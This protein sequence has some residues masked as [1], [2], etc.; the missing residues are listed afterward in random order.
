MSNSSIRKAIWANGVSVC[1]LVASLFYSST[2]LAETLVFDGNNISILQLD[3]TGNGGTYKSLYSTDIYS[4]NVVTVDGGTGG[5][6]QAAWTTTGTINAPYIIYGGVDVQLNRAT[7]EGVTAA[8]I[9]NNQISVSNVKYNW[10]GQSAANGGLG[11]DVTNGGSAGGGSVFGGLS[12]GGAGS[13]GITG[14]GSGGNGG[15]VNGNAVKLSNVDLKGGNGGNGIAGGG[16]TGALSGG[17]GGMGGASIFGGLS[18]GGS[19][20]TAENGGE[21]GSA[22]KNHVTLIDVTLTGGAGGI[23]GQGMNGNVGGGVG[24]MGGGSVYGG[25]SIGGADAGFIPDHIGGYNV[26][27]N[28]SSNRVALTNVTL[29]GAAGG[30]GGGSNAGGGGAGG[31]GGGSVFGGLSIGGA[32]GYQMIGIGTGGAGGSVSENTITLTNVILKGADGGK[33]GSALADAAGLGHDG[34]EGG[35]VFGGVSIGGASGDG[36]GGSGGNVT[37]NTVTITGKSL[38]WGDVYG[39]YSIGGATDSGTIGSGGAATGNT[40]TLEGADIKIGARDDD[41]NVTTYGSIWGGRSVYGDGSDNTDF[42]TVIKGNTLN[43]IGYRGT[44]SGIYNF[45]NYN[46]TL[47][48]DV[49]NGDVLVT[50]ANGG[51]AVDLTDTK[52][53][54]AMVNDGSRLKG[55]DRVTMID[56]TTGSL[57]SQNYTIRQGSF[58]VYDATLAQQNTG[59]NALVLTI[60]NNDDDIPGGGGN[61]GDSNSGAGNSGGGGDDIDNDGNS[62]NGGG[63]SA[64]KINPQSKSYSEGRAAALGFVNQGS[65]LIATAGIDHIRIM[66]RANEDN[67]NRPAFIPFMIANGSSQRYKTGSHVDIDGFNMA[68]GLA[69][70]FDFATGHKATVGTFFEYGRGTYDTYN[71]FTDFASVHGDGDSNYKGGGIFG[72]IDFAGTG[73]G[74]VRQLAADQADGLYVEASLRA[75]RAKSEFDVGRNANLFGNF[76]GVYRGSYDSSVTYYGGHVAGGYVFNVNERQALD[77]FGRYL[78]THMDGDDVSVANEPLHF[79]SSTSSRIQLGGR[80]AYAYSE[81]FKP[82][83]GAAYEYEFDGEVTAKAY[84]FNLDRPSLE[85]STGI[86]EAGFS[87]Q[88]VASNKALS[89]DVNGQGYAGQRQGGGGGIKLKYQF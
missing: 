88:P 79:D 71:S 53:T 67:F 82:Y 37:D 2:S 20:G 21:G 31:M 52:H 7:G 72:R 13:Q 73:L 32:A 57:A 55:G 46:W 64:A 40:I 77:V 62:G 12:S 78:W 14:G 5:A 16:V 6:G 89:I 11:T 1:T 63:G 28:V 87:L 30:D 69:T 22:S 60:N 17:I 35:S 43:L 34:I 83:I 84:E 68:V 36:E 76:T 44:V 58:I 70:G 23:G 8:D 39:G 15:A 61:S 38:I 81:Q 51:T 27:G 48:S 80:Y 86:F 41:G 26:G 29:I 10:S 49:K 25:L 66:V 4:D 47:P 85:G 59:N 18:M 45:E 33:G 42:D 54:I 75:G 9:S 74:R 65:D 19:A 24:G 50:I 3:P 56:K